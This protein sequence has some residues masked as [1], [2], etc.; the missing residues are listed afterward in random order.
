MRPRPRAAAQTAAPVVLHY[1]QLARLFKLLGVPNRLRVL[2]T[3]LAGECSVGDVAR[4]TGLPAATVSRALSP[5]FQH[6]LLS[7]T[8]S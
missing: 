6:E 5:L 2:T 4:A 1:E 3:L 7:L 8:V